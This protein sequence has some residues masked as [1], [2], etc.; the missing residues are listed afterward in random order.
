MGILALNL[1]S[2]F[3]IISTTYV[4]FRYLFLDSLKPLIFNSIFFY[5][6]LFIFYFYIYAK[7]NDSDSLK[8]FT[9]GELRVFTNSFLKFGSNFVIAISSLLIKTL[10]V[11]YFS[12]NLFFGSLG[13]LGLLFL[14]NLIQKKMLRNNFFF[15][16]LLIILFLPS[17]NF[18]TSSIGKDSL[19]F[20]FSSLLVWSLDDYNNSKIPLI[21]LSIFLLILTRLYIAVPVSIIIYFFFPLIIEKKFSKIFYTIYYLS[22][23]ILLI[24]IVYFLKEILVQAGIMSTIQGSSN[25]SL[26]LNLDYLLNRMNS[27]SQILSLAKSNFKD[28]HDNYLFYYFQYTFG[29]FL[30]DSQIGLK[31]LLTKIET[32]FYILMMMSVILFTGMSFNKK[33][34]FYKNIMF[35]M[36]FFSITIPLSLSIS[37]YG[38]SVRQRVLFYPFI[39]YILVSN[40]H[41]FVH[42]KKFNFNIIK[43]NYN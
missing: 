16:V 14:G 13:T 32:Q 28:L 9:D 22:F 27:Q 24:L 11:N 2:I 35:L 7:T 6:L 21:I 37:N 23:F 8:Y 20:L 39:I 3:L 19:I 43:S 17:L 42:E 40:I 34:L 10:K 4:G 41:Y 33:P 26:T 30:F 38:I 1:L 5:H 18:F 25:Y 31:F 29:P 12:L 36:I 15:Y